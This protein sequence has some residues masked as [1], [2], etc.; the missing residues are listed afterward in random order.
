MLRISLLVGIGMLPILF[1]KPSIKKWSVIYVSN[2]ITSH[3]IDHFLVKAGILKY[4]V[5]LV[6]KVFKVNIVYDYLLCPL[7]TVLYCQSSYNSRYVSTIVQG[8]I[9]AIPQVALEYLAEKR[10]KIIKYAKGWTWFHSYLSI[11]ATKLA[12]RGLDEL[13]KP[14]TTYLLKENF[15]RKINCLPMFHLHIKNNLTTQK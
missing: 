10:R 8:F 4:P 13:L 2:A 5:R 11:V 9:F 1:R 15:Q 3:V 12:F 6:P 7:I 14:K